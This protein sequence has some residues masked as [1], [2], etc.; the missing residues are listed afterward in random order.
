MRR[1]D[2][3]ISNLAMPDSFRFLMQK[4]TFVP[5]WIYSRICH[6]SRAPSIQN[7]SGVK[8]GREQS[9]IFPLGHSRSRACDLKAF[10]KTFPTHQKECPKI[11]PQQNK[12]KTAPNNLTGSDQKTAQL[13]SKRFFQQ[14]SRSYWK[15][16]KQNCKTNKYLP[17]ANLLYMHKKGFSKIR[18]VFF[19]DVSWIWVWIC[20][21]YGAFS[22]KSHLFIY[23]NTKQWFKTD[24]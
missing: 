4:K 17:T 24:T 16:N 7:K 9:L 13:F 5:G 14:N 12:L 10:P 6:L 8:I 1:N 23:K 20:L 2:I 22:P 18:F 21:S 11:N 3:I 15:T 19:L